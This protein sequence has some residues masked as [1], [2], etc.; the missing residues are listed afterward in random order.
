MAEEIKGETI[1]IK[2]ACVTKD[3]EPELPLAPEKRFQPSDFETYELFLREW[4][5]FFKMWGTL[6]LG[7]NYQTGR[8]FKT[9][10]TDQKMFLFRKC[11]NEDFKLPGIWP[12]GR[13]LFSDQA[14]ALSKMIFEQ[15]EQ[16]FKQ[17]EK[18]RN[19]FGTANRKTVWYCENF[20]PLFLMRELLRTTTQREYLLENKKISQCNV[21]F[22][23][24]VIV[25]FNTQIQ[26]VMNLTSWFDFIEF[27]GEKYGFPY[28]GY[29]KVHRE[30][31]CMGS[32]RFIES[33]PLRTPFDDDY[34]EKGYKGIAK[35][36]C[37]NCGKTLFCSEGNSGVDNNVFFYDKSCESFF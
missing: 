2:R 4:P 1:I 32:L 34:D 28:K 19:M 7:F 8:T 20:S 18:K 33:Y 26:E 21:E 17:V 25:P 10:S 16:L 5:D 30:N 36:E 24:N 13:R 14:H 6:T 31:D 3:I 12:G 22:N 11:Y 15:H 29:K 35:Y 37:N 9:M 23:K 27:D